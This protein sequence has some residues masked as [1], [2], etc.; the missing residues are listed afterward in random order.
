[1]RSTTTAARLRAN[2]FN[3]PELRELKRLSKPSLVQRFLDDELGYNKEPHGPTCRS[4]RRVLRDR[5]AQCMEGALV[6]A[7]ALEANGYPALLMDLEA[8]RDDDH[9]LA[10]FRQDGCWGA[11]AKSNYSGLRFREPVYRTLREL[12]ISYFEHYYNPR[13]EKTLRRYSRPL[14]LKRFDHLGWRTSEEDLWE[15]PAA[16]CEAVHDSLLT[17]KQAKGLSRMDRRLYEA[18]RV[19]AAL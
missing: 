17:P 15:I 14:A 16:L 9:V 5:V 8:T 2:G 7:A 1:V 12:A 13:G 4:P 18:G 19:G 11:V 3:E 10:V 6:A